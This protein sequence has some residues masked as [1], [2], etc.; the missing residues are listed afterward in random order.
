MTGEQIR[1]LR[2]DLG[3]TQAELGAVVNAH[4]VTVS[5]W[6]KGEAQPDHYQQGM[7]ERFARV[8][9]RKKVGDMAKAALITA[10]VIAALV[11]ILKAAEGGGGK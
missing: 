3:M 11:L 9:E 6:E 2:K 5:K 8:Q 4:F 10:G 7:L 1:H